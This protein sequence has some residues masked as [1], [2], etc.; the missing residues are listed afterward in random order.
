MCVAK[1]NQGTLICFST[2]KD[3]DGFLRSNQ[4]LRKANPSPA[5][6]MLQAAVNSRLLRHK[7]KF[8]GKEICNYR[9]SV[10]V[11]GGGGNCDQYV[12]NGAIAQQTVGR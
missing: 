3:S 1:L 7:N 12:I 4:D 5:G 10:C 11:W 2:E 9:Q 6:S 8:P